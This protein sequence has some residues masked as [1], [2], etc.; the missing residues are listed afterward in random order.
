MSDDSAYSHS[1]TPAGGNTAKQQS[2]WSKRDAASLCCSNVSS[3]IEGKPSMDSVLR[4]KFK[5]GEAT[6]P[7]YGH[8]NPFL[9]CVLF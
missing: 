6:G 7:L 8:H 4:P 9:Y 5:E 2:Y 3:S 1:G